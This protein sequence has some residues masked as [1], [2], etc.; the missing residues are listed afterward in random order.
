MK[1]IYKGNIISLLKQ[2]SKS[3]LYIKMNSA[4]QNMLYFFIKFISVRF[5]FKQTQGTKMF[6][7]Y[8]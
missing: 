4:P 2:T 6:Y 3:R 8:L 1:E 7:I 5:L